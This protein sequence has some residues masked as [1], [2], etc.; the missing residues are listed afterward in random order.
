[1]SRVGI[2]IGDK[3]VVRRYVGDKL[4]WENVKKETLFVKE[5][6]TQF[7]GNLS[8]EN[9]QAKE[10]KEVISLEI[11]GYGTITKD[12]IK[13][14]TLYSWGELRVSFIND[15]GKIG[16]TKTVFKNTK[17]IMTYK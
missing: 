15:L 3:E 7:R 1:M 16:I 2:F 6:T 4:V 17:V 9:V 8:F 12:K 11:L 10:I 5:Q 14:H 13:N